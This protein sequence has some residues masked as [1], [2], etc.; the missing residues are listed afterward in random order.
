M[1]DVQPFAGTKSPNNRKWII[2]GYLTSFSILS[3]VGVLLLRQRMAHIPNATAQSKAAIATSTGLLPL[4]GNLA[5]LQE[6]TGTSMEAELPKIQHVI[7]PEE[8]RGIYLTAYTAGSSRLDELLAYAEK[9]HLNTLVIDVKLDNGEL[10]FDPVDTSLKKYASRYLP[11]TDL[12]S[13]LERLRVKGMYRIARIFVMRDGVYGNLH[14]GTALRDAKGNLWKDKTGTPWLDPAAPEVADYSVALA[15]E[16]YA[17]GFDEIQFD[18]VRFPTDGNI[19]AIRYPVFDQSSTTKASV[20]KEFFRRVG[21]PLYGEHIPFSYDLYGMTFW[22]TDDFQIGQRL[23]DAYPSSTAVSPMVYPSHYPRGFQGFAEPAE[24]PYEIVKQ[25][26]DKGMDILW[27]D[28]P[29]LDARIA[30]KKFRPWI[31]D[32]DIG[33]VYGAD[34]IEAQIKASRDAG[35]G[36][37]LLWNARNVYEPAVYYK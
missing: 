8:V 22:R 18:Y 26:L 14:P 37:W 19:S 9:T 3:L 1:E 7:L 24:H 20:M 30:R 33:A 23:A 17:R 36:G 27:I 4:I 31:Q 21:E 34:K 28:H 32:F 25:S 6:A 13:L 5:L 15:R 10:A 16:A 11:I 12:G 35:S 29:E 2:G